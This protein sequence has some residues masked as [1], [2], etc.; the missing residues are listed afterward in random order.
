MMIRHWLTVFGVPH[1][2]CSAPGPQFN[3]GYFKAMC[4]FMRIRHANSV[5][6]LRR[7]N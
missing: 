3:G 4:S 2:I 1:T 5:A 7:F 6:H